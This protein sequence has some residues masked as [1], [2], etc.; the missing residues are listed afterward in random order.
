[1][2][3]VKTLIQIYTEQ[4]KALGCTIE[5]FYS[6]MAKFNI[7]DCTVK[8]LELLFCLEEA[9]SSLTVRELKEKLCVTHPFVSATARKFQK[10]DLISVSKSKDDLRLTF[11]SL[12][13]KGEQF[14][15]RFTGGRNGI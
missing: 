9:D 10:Q 7:A 8:E 15:K 5:E 6:L 13:E 4:K 2:K 1:M 12:T 3:E 14:L 11:I